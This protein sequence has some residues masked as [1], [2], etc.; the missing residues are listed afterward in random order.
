VPLLLGH[1]GA[2][3]AAPENTL[4]AF[5]L[6]LQHG[7]HGFEFDVRRTADGRAIICHD[8]QL[9]SLSLE[10]SSYAALVERVRAAGQRPQGARRVD[11]EFIPCLEDV[12]DHYSGK[13]FLDI[14]LKVPDMEDSVL[15]ILRRPSFIGRPRDSFIVSS[16]LPQILRRFRDLNPE[17]PLGW[18]CDDRQLMPQ[19]RSLPCEVLVAH[20]SLTSKELIEAAHSAGKK[21]FVWTLNQEEEMRRFAGL[22]ADAIISDDTESLGRVLGPQS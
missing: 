21:L 16:F 15:Q 19:W 10:Q 14:E 20:F 12:V 22:G 5:D 3:R 18:I 8:P 11:N 2:R 6:A 17:I 1:R 7:C 13:A 4:A 9:L